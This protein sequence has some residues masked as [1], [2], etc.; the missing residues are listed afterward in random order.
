MLTVFQCLTLEGW[1]DIWYATNDAMGPE[2]PWIYFVP[3][4]VFVSLVVFGA[5]FILNLVLGA[6]EGQFAK[7]GLRIRFRNRGRG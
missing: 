1:T 7:A 6:L 3:L 5:F 4:V 2:F